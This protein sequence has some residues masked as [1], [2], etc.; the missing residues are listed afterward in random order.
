MFL[1]A[2]YTNS[3]KE[4]VSIILTQRVRAAVIQACTRLRVRKLARSGVESGPQ[5]VFPKLGD[6]LDHVRVGNAE[7]KQQ[8]K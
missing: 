5:N 6:I 4:A 1:L 8:R 2:L 3:N 7:C